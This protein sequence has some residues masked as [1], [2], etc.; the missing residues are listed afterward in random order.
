MA[1][2]W[3]NSWYRA[4]G[5]SWGLI[6]AISISAAAAGGGRGRKRV[7]I[8]RDGK[9]LVFETAAKA[10]QYIE[11]EKWQETPRKQRKK[12]PKHIP[13]PTVIDIKPLE[14]RIS[15]L[16]DYFEIKEPIRSLIRDDRIDF[17]LKLARKLR[18]LDDEE[19]LLL[20]I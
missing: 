18:D 17:L 5:N 7:F 1:S 2:A 15:V 13:K 9:L 12:K 11:Y 6:S 10:A 4:W 3:G 19:I 16:R 8:E 14:N 20:L